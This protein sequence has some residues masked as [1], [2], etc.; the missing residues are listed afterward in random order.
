MPQTIYDL[1]KKGAQANYNAKFR[2][3]NLIEMPAEGTLIVTGDLHGH[4]RNFE[5]IQEYTD[6]QKN[7]Q[8]HV[9][10]QEIIHGGPQN[11]E[12]N[13]I[14]YKLLFDA[15]RYKLEYPDQV[16]I[17]MSNHDTA[18]IC[19]NEII[20]NGKEMNRSIRSAMEGEFQEKC[21]DI[22]NAMKE[23]FLSQPLAVTTPNRIWLSHS[24]PNEHFVDEFDA[25][26]F[27]KP[28]CEDDLK[29]PA[30]AYTL[31]WG[32]RHNQQTLDKMAQI[33]NVDIFILGH[34]N[35][36]EGWC[37]AGNNLIIIASDH[38]HGCLVP[39]E[40]NESYTIERLTDSMVPIS[41]IA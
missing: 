37:K 3:G 12:G 33:L 31:T 28:L 36:P 7:P 39:I 22:I 23:F 17:I 16:H 15:I 5:R 34:Q 11:A 35:Q 18:F 27:E 1:L 14:S 4:R 29:K 13:C 25:S 41:S 9:L 2:R 32:R 40:M 10:L 8:R 19:E 26:I 24:L 20:K 6:L 21:E 30:S 38:N